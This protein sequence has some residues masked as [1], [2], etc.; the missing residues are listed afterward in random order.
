MAESTGIALAVGGITLANEALFTPIATHGYPHINYRVIPA[1]AL[2]AL[3]LYGIEQVSPVLAK[4]IGY[5]A[6]VTV[7]FTS[8]GNAPAPLVN[9]AAIFGKKTGGQKV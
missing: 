5:I 8:F 2:F 6:L 9:L 7:L 4:G 3:G 1:T